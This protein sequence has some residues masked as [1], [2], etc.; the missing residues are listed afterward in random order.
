MRERCIYIIIAR[1][2]I[3]LSD[4]NKDYCIG[5]ECGRYNECHGVRRPIKKG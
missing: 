4:S 5:I 3:G 2:K 1:L